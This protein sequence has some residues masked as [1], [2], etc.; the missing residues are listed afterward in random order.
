MTVKPWD[1]WKSDAEY[2]DEQTEDERIAICKSCDRL[3]KL[4]MQC[5]ECGCFMN[6]KARLKKASCPIKK[7]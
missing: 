6:F 5:K 4:T 3:I 7:W 1:L 2:V